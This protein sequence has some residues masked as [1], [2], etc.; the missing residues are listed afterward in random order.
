MVAADVVR[1]VG[2]LRVA[3]DAGP[4]PDVVVERTRHA[5]GT[6]RITLRSS[7]PRPLRLPVEIALGTDLAELGSIASGR[8]GPELAPS[9]HAAGLRWSSAAG[10]A[11]V[12]ADPPPADALASAGLL[13]WEVELPP[14]GTWSVELRVRLDGAGPIRAVGRGAASPFAP[15]RAVSDRLGAEALLRTS[16]EDLQALLLRDPRHPT[17]IHLAAG[18][19]WRCGLAPADALVAARMTLPLGTRLAVGTLRTLARTQLTGPGPRA[20]LIPGPLRD[21]GPHLPPGAR[22][23]RQRSSSRS[24]SRRPGGGDSRNRR[25][26]NCSRRQS[27]ASNGCGPR[28]ATARISPTHSR[29]DPFAARRRL[30]PT[31]RLCSAPIC[32]THTAG[33]GVWDFGSGLK[34]CGRLSVTTSGPMT[35]AEADRPPPGHRTGVSRPS[36]AR[37]PPI[38][39]TPDCSAPVSRLPVCSTRCAPNS[40]PG[41]S[42]AP[43]WTPAGA[44]QPGGEGSGVQPVRSPRGG[45]A[46]S[47]D[48]GGGRRA[49]RRGL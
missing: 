33:R 25:W 31:V 39:S 47:G 46:R 45:R 9:V 28:S 48:S 24:S 30:T 19:P 3:P 11:A 41:C 13:R 22:P 1:F 17:D 44:A 35:W 15:A 7:S 20:G 40:S 34:T 49:R 10:H 26:R 29:P 5:D 42:E 23:P 27:A 21:A 14:G 16:V 2:T 18:A 4:D 43:P 38:S 36:S 37:V 8:P 6:E 32:S 12:T